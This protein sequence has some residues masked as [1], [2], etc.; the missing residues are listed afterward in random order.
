MHT[1]LCR[2]AGLTDRPD[3]ATLQLSK[4]HNQ[5]SKAQTSRPQKLL[6]QLADPTVPLL[7]LLSSRRTVLLSGL[8]LG[9][10]ASG[11]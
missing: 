7:E 10:L 11:R 6:P 9:G 5:L 2:L 3:A 1:N 8:A 4:A